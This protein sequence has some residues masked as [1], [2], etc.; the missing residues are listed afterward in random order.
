MPK[1]GNPSLPGNY[2]P[3][4]ITSI[5][6]KV[7][8]T[9]LTESIMKHCEDHS[10]ISD[11]QYGFRKRRSTADLLAYVTHLWATSLDKF[12]ESTAVALDI[13]KAFDRVWHPALLAKLCS[14]GV[15]PSVVTWITDFLCNRS[16]AVRV[17]GFTSETHLINAGVPQGC[18][19]SPLLFLLFINDLLGTANIHSFADDSTLHSSLQYNSPASSSRSL[20]ADRH[21]CND[22]LT[23]SLQNIITWGNH[24]RV[25]FNENKTQVIRLSLKR[26]KDTT[27]LAMAG[28][29]LENENSISVLGV[30]ISSDLSWTG[31][32]RDVAK[33]A[34]S[35]LA[36]LWRARKYFNPNQLLVLYKAQI[37]PVMEYCSH[38]WP[39]SAC[40]ILDRIQSKAVRLIGEAALTDSLQ[41]LGH[42]RRVSCL[43][44]FYKY[45]FGQCSAEIANIVPKPILYVRNT[46]KAA[47]INP[48]L[49]QVP[50][51]RTELYK[52]SFLPSTA[53]LWNKLPPHVFP[54]SLNLQQFKQAINRLDLE[55]L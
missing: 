47:N 55:N 43:A 23:E 51:C 12:G 11:R 10:I 37:R 25:A 31:H 46:R 9:L 18:V 39:Q 24:N 3:I 28:R 5:L 17:D 2:R 34:S 53:I 26:E 42:R 44:L 41:S 15:H 8:E 36:V 33:K 1:K 54:A 4:A 13:S 35:R 7:F 14:Y 30:T 40:H 19:L 27:Q 29:S 6:C 49:V 48:Y 52:N 21:S 32:V 45:Y 20:T 50:R 38:I 16:I 22:S